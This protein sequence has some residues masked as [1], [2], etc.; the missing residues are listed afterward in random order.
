M[1]K[2]IIFIF[3]T[4][5]VST[6]ILLPIIS[7]SNELIITNDDITI[8]ANADGW[9]DEIDGIKVVHLKGSFYEMGYQHGSLLKE[10]CYQ[11]F[12]AFINEADQYGVTYADLVNKWDT[13]KEYVPQSHIDGLQGLADALNLSFEYVAAGN[14]ATGVYVSISEPFRI[15]CVNFGCWGSATTDGKLYHARSYDLPIWTQDPES[16]TY[17]IQENQIVI[18]REPDNAYASMSVSI[19]GYTGCI[20][21]V[22][23]KGISIGINRCWSA[24]ETNNGSSP[25]ASIQLV[26]DYASNIE[27]ATYFLN[28]NKTLGYIFTISDSKV[29]ASYIFE[30]SANNSYL[31]AWDSPVESLYPFWEIDHVVRRANL[32]LNSTLASY[33]RERYNPKGFLLWLMGKNEYFTHWR[34]YRALS[35]GI[36]KHWGNLD[37]NNTMDILRKTC[38]GRYDFLFFIATSLRILE[39]WHQWV[40]CP[41]TGDMWVSFSYDGR[42]AF[43][44]SVHHLNFYELLNQD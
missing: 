11:F 19:A 39:T 38:T 35:I 43:K 3:T 23:E 13:R 21:G 9:I 20:G 28:Q 6:T 15:E 1:K 41:E 7:S 36:E 27:E 5:F 40:I 10:E 33:Q 44:N 25:G 18:I 37:A 24:D 17:V 14:L 22:N 34:H 29:P 16:G 12:R 32:Y 4:M 8:N 2:Q 42:S 26:L 31:G 30:T